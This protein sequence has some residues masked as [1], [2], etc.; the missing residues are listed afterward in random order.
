MLSLCAELGE[1]D[2]QKAL[3]G[4]TARQVDVWLTYYRIQKKEQDKGQQDAQATAARERAER[5]LQR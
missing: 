1:W 5:R 4:L 3:R 2:Y